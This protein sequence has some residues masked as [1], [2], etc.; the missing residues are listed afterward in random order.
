MFVDVIPDALQ[1]MVDPTDPIHVDFFN[2]VADQLAEG[3]LPYI[4]D[5]SGDPE[6][7]AWTI[8]QLLRD[9]AN[10]MRE[11]VGLPE[12]QRESTATGYSQTLLKDLGLKHGSQGNPTQTLEQYRAAFRKRK[13]ES[14]A[15][16][17]RRMERRIPVLLAAGKL[18]ENE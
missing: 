9:S 18:V 8:S 1:V 12:R 11:R 7:D 2:R 4:K 14:D 17:K 15:A 3:G 6:K 10:A 13:G 16:A 5:K